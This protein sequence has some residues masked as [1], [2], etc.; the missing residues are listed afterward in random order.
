MAFRWLGWQLGFF[1][2]QR[3]VWQGGDAPTRASVDRVE[4]VLRGAGGRL[5]LLAVVDRFVVP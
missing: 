3:F 1:E 4:G 5:L 2:W